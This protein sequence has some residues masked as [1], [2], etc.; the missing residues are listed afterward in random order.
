M[1]KASAKRV[2]TAAITEATAEREQLKQLGE[3]MQTALSAVNAK[4]SDL[5]ERLRKRTERE[6]LRLVKVRK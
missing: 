4:A 6:P 1:S 5:L 2:A 3:T